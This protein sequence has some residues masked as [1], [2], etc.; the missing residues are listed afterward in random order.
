MGVKS[1]TDDGR[2]HNMTSRSIEY[3]RGILNNKYSVGTNVSD[4]QV[5]RM[6]SEITWQ[7]RKDWTLCPQ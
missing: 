3:V 1:M 6:L 2:D 5:S 7:M 4:N